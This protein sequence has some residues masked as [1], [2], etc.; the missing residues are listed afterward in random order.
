LSLLR[1]NRMILHK[2]QGKRVIYSLDSSFGK[3]TGGKLKLQ[4]PPYTVVVEGL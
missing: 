3:V 4:T 1:M 2:R